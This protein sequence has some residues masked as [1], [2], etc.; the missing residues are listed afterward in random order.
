MS[1]LTIKNDEHSFSVEGPEIINLELKLN[2][3]DYGHTWKKIGDHL[4]NFYNLQ[5]Y[6]NQPSDILYTDYE[7][8]QFLKALN[9]RTYDDIRKEYSRE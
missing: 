8:F 4:F 9:R 5:N 3:T 1:K 7:Q 6:A 2:I